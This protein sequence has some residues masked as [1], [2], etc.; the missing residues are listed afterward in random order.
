[1]PQSALQHLPVG[2]ANHEEGVS[3]STIMAM[4]VNS[5]LPVVLGKLR[6]CPSP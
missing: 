5:G 1:V 4:A 3:L 2:L 6:Q